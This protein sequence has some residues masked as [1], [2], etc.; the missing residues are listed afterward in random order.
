MKKSTLIAFGLACAAVAALATTANASL[1]YSTVASTY[2]QNFDSLPNTPTNT[3]IQTSAYTSGWQDDSTSTATTV[4]IP[5]WYLYHPTAATEGGVSGHSRLRFGS[6]GSSTGAFYSFGTNSTTDRAL[7]ALPAST[8]AGDGDSM[9]IA[10]R[11]TN[12]T[13]VALST[14]TITYDGEQYRDGAAEDT[15]S[16]SYAMNVDETNWFN[17]GANAVFVPGAVFTPPVTADNDATVAGNVA[18]LVPNI[19]ATVNLPSDGLWQPGTDIFLRW[20]E[21]Q[22]ASLTDDG[23]AIDNVRFSADVPEPA[24]LGLLGL[25]SL[26]LLRR[27]DRSP[28]R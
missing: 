20:S 15:M 27:R 6:G 19:T 28:S 4:G 2:T 10:L 22:V 13:G 23:L 5:G 18:G 26:A 9:R 8:L 12:D 14:F 7:G 17:A 25:A 3:N 11:L 21:I 16:F 1:S 24:S